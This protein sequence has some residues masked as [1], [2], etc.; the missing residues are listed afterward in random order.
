VTLHQNI[1]AADATAK[2]TLGRCVSVAS[3]ASRVSREHSAIGEHGIG[4]YFAAVPG[5]RDIAIA[6][7]I[8]EQCIAADNVLTLGEDCHEPL[9][10]CFATVPSTLPGVAAQPWM[11][12]ESGHLSAMGSQFFL[13]GP[14]PEAILRLDQ[15]HLLRRWRLIWCRQCA[16]A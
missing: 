7:S 15:P 9:N 12:P 2:I 13:I 4:I 11:P 14:P 5:I 1:W 6:Q 3:L 8:R 10:G 16:L